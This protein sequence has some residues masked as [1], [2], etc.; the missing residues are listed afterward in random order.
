MEKIV[1][2]SMRLIA[3][4]NLNKCV[5]LITNLTNMS[6]VMWC[7]LVGC[8]EFRDVGRTY[9]VTRSSEIRRKKFEGYDPMISGDQGGQ[10]LELRCYDEVKNSRY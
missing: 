4:Q 10:I 8:H 5:S 7:N 9:D 2:C 3:I 1:E 6:T